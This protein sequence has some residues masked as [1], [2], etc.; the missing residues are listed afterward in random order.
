MQKI[1]K[2]ILVGITGKSDRDWQNK[3]KEIKHY[4]LKEVALF[5]ELFDGKQ[6]KKIYQALKNFDLKIP[7]IHIRNDMSR[8]ELKYLIDKYKAPCLTIHEDSF[9]YLDKWHGC[10]QHLFLE[11]NYDNFINA[12]V[13]LNRIGGLCLDLSHFKAS[14]E[15]WSKE[16]IFAIRKSKNKF[17]CNHLN[18][19]S[20]KKKID[21]HHIKN[22]NEFDYLDTLPAFVFGKIIALETFNSIK[23]QLKFKAY[24]EK[25]ILKSKD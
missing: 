11:L 17:V 4:H 18:G 7:L 9:K 1:S 13:N 23:M 6:R 14:E 3:L 5:L 22:L 10:Y 8:D 21:V 2:K 15:R 12:Q 16:F 24:L 19:F 20:Y 25:E